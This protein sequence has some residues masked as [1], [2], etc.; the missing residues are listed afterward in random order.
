VSLLQGGVAAQQ[1]LA[2]TGWGYLSFQ[3]LV[4]Q[5]YLY[6]QEPMFKSFPSRSGF[7]LCSSG[8][9]FV[10]Q[11]GGIASCFQEFIISTVVRARVI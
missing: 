7:G 5:A 10:N 2:Y 4:T 8:V 11:N 6:R 3:T 9:A 1:H